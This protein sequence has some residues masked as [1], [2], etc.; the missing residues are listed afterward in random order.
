MLQAIL[1]AIIGT[2][3]VTSITVALLALS[4]RPWR[5]A[6]EQPNPAWGPAL[7]LGVG[8]AI[9]HGYLMGWPAIPPV[10]GKQWVFALA[11]LAAL[12]VSVRSM[13]AGPGWSRYVF[14]GLLSLAVPLTTLQAKLKFGWELGEAVPAIG[15]IAALIFLWLL[16]NEERANEGEGAAVPLALAVSTFGASI[17]LG[18]SSSATLAELAGMLT[19]GI[20]IYVLACWRWQF[21]SITPGGISVA[22]VVLAGLLINGY[23]FADLPPAGALL[24]GAAPEAVRLTR[25]GP[26][27]NV[28]GWKQAL[29]KAA[30][31]AVP[32]G[33][34]VGL[35]L[36]GFLE[37][38]GES[39]PYAGY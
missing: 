32:V 9:A 14:C 33:A 3:L 6:G 7:G 30:L 19:A 12:L 21:L 38:T 2:L 27:K 31:V 37:T 23:F 5:G 24:L 13:T 4:A 8:Y 35:A 18:L 34:A 10:T 29:T 28:T 36:A 20:S 25:L 16:S 26:L 39:D 1:P 17:A 22:G 15:L 11:L